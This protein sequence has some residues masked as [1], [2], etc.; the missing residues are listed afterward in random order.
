MNAG[1]QQAQAIAVDRLAVDH[2]CLPRSITDKML[3]FA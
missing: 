3:D 1:M 2:G